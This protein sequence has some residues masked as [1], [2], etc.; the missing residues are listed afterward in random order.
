MWSFSG[1]CWFP[2]F[3]SRSPWLQMDEKL[4]IFFEKDSAQTRMKGFAG[5][6][7]LDSPGRK[8][9]HLFRVL[10]F[11]CPPTFTRLRHL[12][13]FFNAAPHV[14]LCISAARSVGFAYKMREGRS[15]GEKRSVRRWGWPSLFIWFSC[16]AQLSS[17]ALG[18]K[19]TKNKI[20]VRHFRSLSI[21]RFFKSSRKRKKK[22]YFI[23]LRILQSHSNSEPPP[24]QKLSK[25]PVIKH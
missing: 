22:L 10:A 17:V 20:A 12:K 5:G 3:S 4:Y 14:S 13:P 6:D 23:G 7:P 1:V 16:I 19:Q 9:G 24:P 15:D 25:P 21:S 18:K 8:Q 2:A 11:A